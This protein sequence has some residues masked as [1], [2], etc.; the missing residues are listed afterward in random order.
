MSYD[1]E[2]GMRFT[3]VPQTYGQIVI[4]NILCEAV[5]LVYSFWAL[6]YLCWGIGL[7]QSDSFTEVHDAA[8]FIFYVCMMTAVYGWLHVM[9]YLL[10][11]PRD[12]IDVEIVKLQNNNA[13]LIS[14]LFVDFFIYVLVRPVIVEQTDLENNVFSAARMFMVTFCIVDIWY[15]WHFLENAYWKL[16]L[17]IV[18]VGIFATAAR[19]LVFT[20]Q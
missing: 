14:T 2:H 20:M 17:F 16:Y 11:R 3:M 4:T 7:I 8:G 9:I 5:A 19:Y 1:P 10:I 6:L 18:S 13:R 15:D 12:D